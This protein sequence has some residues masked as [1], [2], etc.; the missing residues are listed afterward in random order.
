MRNIIDQAR[1]Q[2]PFGLSE[3][4]MCSGI[5]HGCSKKLLDFL[6]MELESW[7]FRLDQGEHPNFGDIRRLAKMSRKIF[8]A[9]NKSGLIKNHTDN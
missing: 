2:I 1:N 6:E 4:Q 9:L 3:A 7:E 5:C 8:N